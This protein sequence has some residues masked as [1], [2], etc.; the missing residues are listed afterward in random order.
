MARWIVFDE[1][2]AAELRSRLPKESVFEAPG[3]T[4]LEYALTAPRTV[5]AVLGPPIHEETAIAIF[6]SAGATQAT[7]AQRD[8]LPAAASPTDVPVT[9]ASGFLGLSDYVV[10][11]EEDEV[12]T[13]KPWWK[14]W[15]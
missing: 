11:A 9:R 15:R 13:Q 12:A 2:T 8:D 4:A 7:M 14:F 5:V 10:E 3:R 6:R 1:A